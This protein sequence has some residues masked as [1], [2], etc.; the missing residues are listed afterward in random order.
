MRSYIILL[1]YIKWDSGAEKKVY[2]WGSLSRFTNKYE[3]DKV[4]CK[5]MNIVHIHLTV[6][7]KRVNCTD[8]SRSQ[9]S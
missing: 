2:K 6:S 9:A 7:F 4:E 5:N 3:D 8:Q 1:E